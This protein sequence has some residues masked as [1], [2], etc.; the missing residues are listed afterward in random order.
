MRHSAPLDLIWILALAGAC[1][2]G[3]TVPDGAASTTSIPALGVY[4]VKVDGTALRLLADTGTRQIT[5]L[6]KQPGEAWM[7]GT[8]YQND[9]DHNGYAM[10]VEGDAASY[11]ATEIIVFA[12][13]DVAHATVIAGGVPDKLCANASWTVDGRLIFVQQ[14]DPRDANWTRIKRARFSTVPSVSG[15]DAVE[16]P[17]T[18]LV[19]TDAHQVGPSDAT[20]QIVFASFFHAASGWSH[21]AWRIPAA[22]TVVESS[23]ALVGCP[24]CGDTCCAFAQI[25]QV[26]GVTDP[27]FNHAGTEVSFMQ[28]SPG[29]SFG[30]PA[31]HPFRQQRRLLA[32]ATQTD[33]TGAEIAPETSLTFVDW[34][35]DDLEGVYWSIEAVGGV[36]RN[37]LY[38]MSPDGTNRTRIALPDD[39]CPTHPS[40]VDDDTIV[41]SAWRCGGTSCSCDVGKI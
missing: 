9:L 33:L 2:P 13:D 20:G 22:G 19:P 15:I 14:D 4:Q 1:K 31:Q 41:F 38:T 30:T 28:Q 37:A 29:V 25:D 8:R 7:T 21:P 3:A 32:S 39:L 27:R 36:V 35:A 10:E 11:A 23:A 24:M 18:L 5:H 26:L 12:L 34:R 17:A 6:R 16:L 40:Y